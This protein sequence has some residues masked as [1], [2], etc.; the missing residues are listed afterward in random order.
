M[1]FTTLGMCVF[2]R[3]SISE[4]V[5]YF[6]EIMSYGKGRRKKTDERRTSE[7]GGCE[8]P[9]HFYPE[10]NFGVRITRLNYYISDCVYTTS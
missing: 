8:Q 1:V 7:E 6:G 2:I 4:T 5:A 9:R 10:L 3:P